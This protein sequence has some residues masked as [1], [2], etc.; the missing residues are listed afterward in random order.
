VACGLNTATCDLST[1]GLGT[2][3]VNFGGCGCTDCVDPIFQCLDDCT[4]TCLDTVV[5]PFVTCMVTPECYTP[6]QEEQAGSQFV[7][8]FPPL[9]TPEPCTFVDLI[10]DPVECLFPVFPACDD[11]QTDFVD[12]T[13]DLVSCCSTCHQEMLD[14]FDC[15]YNW[16]SGYECAAFT[17]PAVT[18]HLREDFSWM[19]APKNKEHPRKLESTTD[20]DLEFVE[21]CRHLISQDLVERP[22]D[23][24]SAYMNCIIS[25]TMEQVTNEANN[26]QETAAPTTPDT[27]S[28]PLALQGLGAVL[29]IAAMI[30]MLVH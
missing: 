8:V 26:P 5:A 24:V 1:C 29:S 20:V 4:P 3:Q 10:A 22:E 25:N 28:A 2:D 14:V 15:F 6:C 30:L 27:S 18:R 16:A 21:E 11:V 13:C 12:V 9:E 23:V 19:E 7:G 17:C